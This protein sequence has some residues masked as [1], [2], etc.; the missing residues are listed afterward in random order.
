MSCAAVAHSQL[1]VVE[2]DPEILNLVRGTLEAEG[3]AVIPA[4][5][6][7]ASLTLLREHLFH[8][9]VTDLFRE[10]GH[11][12]LLSIHPLLARAVP[13]PVGV[14]TGWQVSEEAANQAG[15][16]FL[17]YKPFDLDDLVLAVQHELSSSLSHQRQIQLSSSSR[18]LA[19]ATG[20]AWHG[21]VPLIWQRRR[22]AAPLPGFPWARVVGC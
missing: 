16:S 19:R 20:S 2:D 6:L 9:I 15:L 13:T 1:L 14:I 8:L 4:T 7:P 3:C 10:Q 17:L 5:S 21:S 12:P 11:D 22:K 18:P